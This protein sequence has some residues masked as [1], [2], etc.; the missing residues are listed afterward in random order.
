M[1]MTLQNHMVSTEVGD[2]YFVTTC[3]SEDG[4]RG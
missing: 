3:D 4:G 1:I 2:P